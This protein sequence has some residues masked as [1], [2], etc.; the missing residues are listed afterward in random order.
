MLS[1]REVLA[2]YHQAMLDKSADDLADL[3]ATDAV[4]EFPFEVPGWP[5]KLSG[6]EEIR[7]LYHRS[8]SNVPFQLTEVHDVAVSECGDTVIGEWY[9]TGVTPDR[10]FTAKG[11]LV[12]RVEGGKIVHMRDYMDVFGTF[13][14]LGRLPAMV[15]AL[16][17]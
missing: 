15:A 14:S 5:A 10:A 2:R 9:G 8:W 17:D 3:Y 7:S 11:V 13:R 12:F 16:G 1:A 4:H 6:R